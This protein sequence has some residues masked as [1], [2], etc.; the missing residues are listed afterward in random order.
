MI[1]QSQKVCLITLP[2]PPHPPQEESAGESYFYKI[3]RLGQNVRVGQGQPQAKCKVRKGE[4]SL[5]AISLTPISFLSKN[6]S[7]L[8]VAFTIPTP[9]SALRLPPGCQE[10]PSLDL[11]LPSP[12]NTSSSNKH[13]SNTNNVK[14]S[15]GWARHLLHFGYLMSLSLGTCHFPVPAILVGLSMQRKLF[16]ADYM[17]PPPPSLLLYCFTLW[18]SLKTLSQSILKVS[19]FSPADSR[20][21]AFFLPPL[22]INNG[23]I[24]ASPWCTE[25][26]ITLRWSPTLHH[27]QLHPILFIS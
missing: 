2:P 21:S 6:F 16:H 19:W 11:G 27:Q 7:H 17:A 8:S 13:E 4:S 24:Q 22:D 3:I 23:Y 18:F 5:S 15:M 12:G 14:V 26:S 1:H 9:I 20:F 10:F 25:I